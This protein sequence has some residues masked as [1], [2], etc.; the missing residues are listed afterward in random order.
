[1][2]NPLDNE[3]L[4]FFLRHRDDIREWAAIEA[5][6]ALATRDI[7]AACQADIGERLGVI[8]PSAEVVRHDGGRYERI[9]ARRPMWPDGIGVALEWETSVDPFG[10]VLPKFG[11][12]VLAGDPEAE[13]AKQRMVTL[14]RESAAFRAG[15][16]KV[17]GDQ[18]WPA[19]RRVAKS[20]TWWQD[21]DAWAGGI[22]DALVELW[23][24]GAR[25]IDEALGAGTA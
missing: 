2:G 21:P 18:V 12:F 25:I 24:G 4:Q 23:P 19:V 7:L 8:D 20:S 22:V 3:R 9:L 16:F 17:P 5:E 1:V 6:V 10:G 13:P 11:V 14:A 15:G